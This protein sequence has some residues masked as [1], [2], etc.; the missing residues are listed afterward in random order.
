MKRWGTWI[1]A[2][3]LLGAVCLQ[4]AQFLHWNR[5]RTMAAQYNQK[6]AAGEGP[7]D[8][9]SLEKDGTLGSVEFPGE[10][11]RRPI[12]TGCGQES[13]GLG[14]LRF[15][16]IPIGGPGNNTVLTARDL[17]RLEKGDSFYIRIFGRKLTYQ[18]DEIAQARAYA[19]QTVSEADR[20]TLVAG[21]TVIRATRVS[22]SQTG[23]WS[24][25]LVPAALTAMLPLLRKK[26]TASR[27]RRRSG[28]V[29]GYVP[30]RR[31]A[32]LHRP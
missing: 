12:R 16:S 3:L 18:V 26:R 32:S 29:I 24:L 5:L 17:P 22:G 28:S 23:L 25:V 9:R 1:M 21:G 11:K 8:L 2:A 15:S 10:G 30:D 20:I 4:V 7:Q 14:Y 6:L 19:L 31:R 13:E 27:K